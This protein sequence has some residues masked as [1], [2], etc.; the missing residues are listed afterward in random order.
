M[1]IAYAPA[2]VSV[3]R[4]LSAVVPALLA[5]ALALAPSAA[6]A[7]AV[8]VREPAFGLPH[9][10]ADTDLELAR[11]NGR[12]T[13]KDRLGQMI[14][15]GRV[16]RG[17]LS[18]AFGLLDSGAIDDDIETRRL[19]YTSS[20]LNQMFDALPS[21]ERDLILEYCK[22]VNDTIEAIFAGA[23]PEPIEVSL[24]RTVLINLGD[25]LFGNKTNISDQLDPFF[26]PPGDEWPTAGFQFTPEIA[27]SIGVLQVRNFGLGGFSESLFSEL[28]ALIAQHGSSNGMAIWDD[29]HFL[30]D[31]LAPVS[32]PDGT[33]PGFGGPLALLRSKASSLLAKR[34]PA[35]DYAA[36]VALR[37]ER[38]AARVERASRLGAWPKL[39]SYAWAIGPG[40]S[41][42]GNPWLGGFPQTGE[43]T[44]SIMH[45]A[46]NRSAEPGGIRGNGMEFVG[47]PLVLIGHT[48]RV[49]WTTTTAQLPVLDTFFEEIVLED[50]DAVRYVDE[51]TPAPLSKRSE[52]FPRNGAARVFWR[53]HA[54]NGNG[55]SR[56][57]L[58][59]LGDRTGTATGGNATQLVASGAFD[60]SLVGGHVAIIGGPGAGQIRAITAVPNADTLEVTTPFTTPPAAKSEYVV[61]GSTGKIIAVAIDSAAW[62]EET[63]SVLGFAKYQRATSI[64][65]IRAGTRLIP[66]THNFFAADNLAWNAIGTDPGQPGNIGFWSSGFSRVRQDGGDLRLPIDGA[67]P[68]PLVDIAGAVDAATATTLTAAGAFAGRNLAPPAPNARYD[69]PVTVPSEFIVSITSGTGYKQTRRVA[70]NDND[71]LTVE[72]PFGVVPAGGD[73]FEVQEILGMPEAVNPAEGYTANWNNKAA[74]ADP[75]DGFGRNHRVAFILERLANDDLWD[76]NKQQ[77]LN[78]AVAG[79]DGRGRF[80]RYLIPRLREAVDA[81]GNGGNPAVDTALARLEQWNG[82]PED[83]RNFIDPVA[84][85]MLAGE[86]A[87]LKSIFTAIGNAIY[88]DEFGA[89]GVPGGSDGEALVI[90]AIDAAAGDVPGARLQS[91]TGDYFNGIDWKLVVRNAFAAEATSGIPADSPR[92]N[93]SFDHPLAAL[94]TELQFPQIPT[95]NRGTYEQIVEVG[96]TVRGEFIFPLGQSAQIEG[97]LSGVTAIDPNATSLHPVWRDWRFVPM[98]SVSQDLAI[99]PSGDT[100]GDG[101]LDG[102]ERFFFASLAPGAD[103]DQDADG[104]GVLG[105][106]L[107]GT[108][109]TNSDTDEDGS[110]DGSDQAPQDRLL[111]PEPGAALQW[112]VALAALGGLARRRRRAPRLAPPRVHGRAVWRRGPQCRR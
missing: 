97:S 37:K 93:R 11:E 2:I 29:R 17:T 30:N 44:P 94:F 33:T 109:P 54:R 107:A 4:H 55:G 65:D 26:A 85:T 61:V 110:L 112:L 89:L 83:G 91:F 96:D 88:A 101:L 45:Y 22:G 19:G 35:Y 52:L 9:L 75:G 34:F 99:D 3:L 108:D 78:G 25:D 76:R 15:I 56:P 42:S 49:A 41:A 62:F 57:V 14:L 38:N 8:T 72:S 21:A 51:G 92:P 36:A 73:S 28:Q 50:V 70:G 80:G 98:L 18:Q 58:D 68:N 40:K 69:D 43:L 48:D 16:A 1:P 32:V 47:A 27:V 103:T 39:G 66:T 111:V 87:F 106:F 79:L 20:E 23:L 104:L 82:E 12:E 84:D 63:T 95:G 10:F 60:A 53:S 64:L 67:L 5:L 86:V 100:D 24:L 7:A 6:H 59:F 71:T 77:Q 31:P 105:E 74:T 81:V 90:H 46:E 102:F 13:A